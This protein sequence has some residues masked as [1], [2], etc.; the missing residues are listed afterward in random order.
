[1]HACWRGGRK[2]RPLHSAGCMQQLVRCLQLACVSA[3]TCMVC[4]HVGRAGAA[5]HVIGKAEGEVAEQHGHG[6]VVVQLA[7]RLADAGVRPRAEG[8]VLARRIL[9]HGFAVAAAADQ[10]LRANPLPSS[11]LGHNLPVSADLGGLGNNRPR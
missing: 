2:A 4:M 1:M 5:A 7:Q 10:V 3:C 11:T 8:D 9:V 6:G